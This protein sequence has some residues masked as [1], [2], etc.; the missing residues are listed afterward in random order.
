MRIINIYKSK[1]LY[2][3]I[4]QFTA[5]QMSDLIYQRKKKEQEDISKSVLYF[6]VFPG[7]TD[8]FFPKQHF[9]PCT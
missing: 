3:L 8:L 5:G 4:F 6:I 9:F 2:S 7:K 1:G